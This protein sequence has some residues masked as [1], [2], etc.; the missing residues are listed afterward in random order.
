MNKSLVRLLI[1]LLLAAVAGGGYLAWQGW[2]ARQTLNRLSEVV[3]SADLDELLHNP[4]DGLEEAID[5]AVRGV[6]LAQ[7]EAGHESWTLDADWAT[8]RQES[9]L[10][11]VNSP[12]VRYAV[13]D[14]DK[15]GSP[16]RQVEVTAESGRIENNNSLLTMEGKVRAEY[17]DEVLTGSVAIFRND[18]RIL[19][20]PDGARLD[21]PTL[22]GTA[23]SLRWNLATNIL[24]GEHGVDVVW[25]P[26]SDKPRPSA[27]TPGD[28]PEG[29][30]APD[31]ASPPES[32]PSNAHRETAR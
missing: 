12:V 30:P 3:K 5:L 20:F 10:V 26:R 1:A 24:D 23:G 21:G 11:Q 2:R 4:P 16:P 9:G 13:G 29:G 8:L 14:P 15:G 6:R 7:G 27:A 31:G 25:T 32:A 22:A 18:T 28:A 19:L 17:Q